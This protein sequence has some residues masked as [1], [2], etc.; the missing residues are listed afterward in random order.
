MDTAASPS[1]GDYT[2]QHRLLDMRLLVITFSSCC[3]CWCVCCY[4]C[5]YKFRSRN[6]SQRNDGIDGRDEHRKQCANRVD[7]EFVTTQCGKH[8]PVPPRRKEQQERS[9]PNQQRRCGHDG[10]CQRRVLAMVGCCQRGIGAEKSE[11]GARTDQAKKVRFVARIS[12]A[13]SRL[14][15]MRQRMLLVVVMVVLC[16]QRLSLLTS[17]Q[18]IVL[19]PPPFRE[20]STSIAERS[21][22][23]RLHF[24]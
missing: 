23:N 21:H 2:F 14:A 1:R 15:W 16:L 17:K 22:S 9:V 4:S 3:V 10:G 8:Q 7:R 18:Y 5:C 12:S 24:D 11:A 13:R 19:L 20:T 6:N